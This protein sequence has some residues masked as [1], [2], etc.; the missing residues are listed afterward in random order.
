MAVDGI[1][2]SSM[3]SYLNQ[4]AEDKNAQAKA[5]SA[6]GALS[7]LSSS[8]SR[9]D[10][11]AAAKSFEA[12]FVEQV[13]KQQKK[14]LDAFKDED[15]SK[16][17]TASQYTDLHMDTMYQS[18]AEKIVDQYGGDF[19]NTMVDQIM[20]N[21]GIL[22]SS[23]T[24]ATDKDS[25]TAQANVATGAVHADTGSGAAPAEE[26]NSTVTIKEVTGAAKTTSTDVE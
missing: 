20:R 8:S 2:G 14:I 16:D 3:A 4:I 19:T 13:I 12:Y 11:T 17:S 9:E 10:V 5:S 23:S 1:S 15:S 18:M 24:K 22:D 7:G 26:D 21:Y 6:T 25:T